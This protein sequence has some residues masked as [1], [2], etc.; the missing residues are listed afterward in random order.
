M[1]EAIFLST[2]QLFVPGGDSSRGSMSMCLKT[3]FTQNAFNTQR[4]GSKKCC[5]KCLDNVDGVI[6]KGCEKE[7]Q[8]KMRG[9]KRE[10]LELFP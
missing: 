7:E 2:E 1:T 5:Q 3:F 9:G 4:S 10:L 6:G 8:L